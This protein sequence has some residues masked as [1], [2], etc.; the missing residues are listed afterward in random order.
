MLTAIAAKAFGVVLICSEDRE[1]FNVITVIKC[2]FSLR[3]AVN[4]PER[5]CLTSLAFEQES[6][7]EITI[8]V[9]SKIKII[10]SY[11]ISR[12]RRKCVHDRPNLHK[13]KSF[14]SLN[15]YLWLLGLSSPLLCAFYSS[16]RLQST[17]SATV[18]NLIIQINSRRAIERFC[19]TVH[20][21]QSP[22]NIPP[23]AFI[24]VFSDAD[25]EVD[26]SQTSILI[27]LFLVSCTK[28]RY[29]TP[30]HSSCTSRGVL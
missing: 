6:K 18:N 5:F 13:Q 26:H 28:N 22:R 8:I 12:V 3:T 7:M 16:H 27:G 14:N 4:G 23:Q 10:Y 17:Q 19:T 24:V 11:P 20:Y 15:G 29:F 1:T 30:E 2:H 25:R 21:T 9:N